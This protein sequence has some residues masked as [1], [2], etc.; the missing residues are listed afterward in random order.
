VITSFERKPLVELSLDQL[1]DQVQVKTEDARVGRR[2]L[3]GA[4]VGGAAIS[5]LPQLATKTSASSGD[6][7]TTV[8]TTAAPPRR[9]T[10][11]D[12]A[13]LAGTQLLELTARALYDAAIAAG[14]WSD[15]E[16]SVITTIREAHEAAAQSLAGMLGGDA[17]GEMSPSLYDS[18]VN[19]FE[20]SI[21]GRLTAAY[22]LES[23]LVAGHSA[24]LGKLEGIDGATLIAAIQSAEA[25]HGTVLA[26]LAGETEVS[27]LLVVAE[28]AS[29][30]VTG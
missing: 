28:A 5:L 23:A 16:V 11:V 4:G 17:P 22:N 13:V 10:D 25:R 3:L 15:T 24:A 6:D 2:V 18:L 20:G 9:P 8:P 21:V 29:L 7:S 1:L 30:E 26:D 27:T 14:D 12:I 19:G